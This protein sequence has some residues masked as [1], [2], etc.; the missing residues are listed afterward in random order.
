MHLASL[1]SADRTSLVIPEGLCSNCRQLISWITKVSR[2]LQN[3]LNISDVLFYATVWRKAHF[4][5]S[6]ASEPKG[7][8]LY[9]TLNSN[10]EAWLAW[11]AWFHIGA[12]LAAQLFSVNVKCRNSHFTCTGQCGCTRVDASC[13]IKRCYN[14]LTLI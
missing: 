7:D 11:L 10:P 1:R 5:E 9:M 14:S 6:S 3:L 4:P 8:R 12:S 2:Y 13:C